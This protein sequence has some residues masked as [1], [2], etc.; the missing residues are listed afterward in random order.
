MVRHR[1]NRQGIKCILEFSSKSQSL[2]NS[3]LFLKTSVSLLLDYIAIVMNFIVIVT[4][5]Q[6]ISSRTLRVL[7]CSLKDILIYNDSPD[8]FEFENTQV[9][10][11]IGLPLLRLAKPIVMS[12]NYTS[13]ETTAHL[14]EICESKFAF[15]LLFLIFRC[16]PPSTCRIHRCYSHQSYETSFGIYGGFI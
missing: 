6:M 1:L 16:C 2:S 14:L 10:I 12:I 4:C 15:Y 8:S 3:Y 11:A 9:P 5:F 13:D 7:G